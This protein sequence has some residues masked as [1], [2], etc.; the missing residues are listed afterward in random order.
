MAKI[1]TDENKIDE[2]LS[3][4]VEE[5]IVKE[6]LK[7]RL[8]SGK[9]LRIKLGIDPTGSVL[10]LG[11][12][13]V[14]RKLKDF[15][16]LGHQVIFLIG[17]FTARIGDPTGRSVSRKPLTDK[18]IAANMKSYTKQAGLILD[19]KKVE[20]RYNSEWLNKLDFRELVM[21]SSKVTYAQVAQRADFKERIKNDQDLSLQ[22]FL[23]PVMQGYDSVA[24]KADVEIGGTDQ[25]FN[26]L[27]GRQLQ[28]R[29]NQE[30]QE[31]ITCP[32]LEGL[33]GGDKMSKS[34]DNYIALTEKPEEMYGKIMSLTDG[35]IIRY[36]TLGTYLS[37]E[38]IA[39][40]EQ[41]LGGGKVN[42]RDIKMRL[43]LE[44]TKIYHGEKKAVAAQEY[45]VKTVQKK[46][47]PEEV[48]SKKLTVGSMN[49]ME[50]L[51]EVGLTASKGEAR[52]LIEQGGIKIDGSAV[53]DINKI[54]EITANGV[55]VQRGKRG[56]VR[57]VKK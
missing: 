37:L 46:E 13:V 53:N 21:L 2:V 23:Y 47:A 24:L 19:M 40:I 48:I 56:F 12:A 1:I 7:K 14:L 33:S 54:I 30:P 26:L 45:F 3:R 43:A 10:H 31:I 38:K 28:K 42:P 8:M 4:G 20:I 41:E 44:I 36:F 6:N 39:E 17:D 34:L 22:E 49:I 11:H 32:L 9:K 55:L 57:V 35:L 27:M 51:V 18:D 50:L 52:R 16:D 25:K 15:Q 29:Y 5:V